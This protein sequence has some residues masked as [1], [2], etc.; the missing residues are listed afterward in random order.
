MF[1]LV[2]CEWGAWNE[3]SDCQVNDSGCV[4][5]LQRGMQQRNRT[6]AQQS[7]A[8]GTKCKD[9]D[10]SQ[11]KE[12]CEIECTTTTLTTTTEKTTISVSSTV[13]PYK[14]FITQIR[15]NC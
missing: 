15:I 10:A 6:I 1:I 11:I 8:N 2:D 14:Y 7:V 5:G 9:S 12:G 13:A 3:W 4:E